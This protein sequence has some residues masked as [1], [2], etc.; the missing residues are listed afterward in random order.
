M[1]VTAKYRCVIFASLKNENI[2]NKS[3]TVMFNLN[4]IDNFWKLLIRNK[5]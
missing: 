5:I 1:M 4:F 2:W 3:K